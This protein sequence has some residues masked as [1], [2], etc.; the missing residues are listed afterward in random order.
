MIWLPLGTPGLKE[1]DNE[2]VFVADQELKIID[3]TSLGDAGT[4][5]RGCH[6]AVTFPDGKHK[7]RD[8]EFRESGRCEGRERKMKKEERR[9]RKWREEG[10][11]RNNEDMMREWENRRQGTQME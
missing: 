5:S 4:S 8:G 6:P 1:L 9:R 7:R 2:S 11:D 3:R 10:E